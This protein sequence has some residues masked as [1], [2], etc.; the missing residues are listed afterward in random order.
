MPL[1]APPVVGNRKKRQAMARPARTGRKG[2]NLGDKR[3]A[4][5][6]DGL[7]AAVATGVPVVAVGASA[8]GL[9]PITRLLAAIPAKNGLAFVVIQHLDPTSKSLLPELLGR[10]TAMT[11]QAATDGIKVM[12]DQ[13]YVIPPGAHLTIGSGRLH[14]STRPTAAGA[15]LPI[16]VFLQSLATQCGE[17]GIGVILSGSG[18]DGAEGL[19]ALKQAGGLALVQDPEE[20]QQDSM[21]RQAMMIANPD[22]VLR[23][24][25]MPE[26]LARY[27]AHNYVKARPSAS[28]EEAREIA[29]PAALAAIIERLKSAT[30]QDFARYKTGTLQRRVER[31]MAL[32]GVHAWADYLA[33]LR[34]SPVETSALAKDLLINVTRFFRDAGAFSAMA[35]RIAD[36]LH[37]HTSDQPARIWVAG[38]S[39]GEEAYSLGILFREQIA[40]TRAGLGLQI[41]AT[42]IDEDALQIG[43]AGLYPGSIASDVSPKR[44]KQFFVQEDGHFKVTKELREAVIFSR[45][46]VL[47]DSPFS[48]LDLVSCRNLLIYLTP[49]AQAH[50]LALA[51][52]ALREGG[53]LLLGSA[54]SVAA[55]PGLFEPVDEKLRIYRRSG[56]G[57]PARARFSILEP[58]Q[59]S[60]AW[61]RSLRQSI[62]RS[63]S[64]PDLVQRTMLETYA[65][66]AVVTNRQLVPLYFFGGADRYL[67]IVSGEPG[68]DLL[69]IAREGLR[70]KLRD[71]IARAFRAKRRVSEHGVSFEREGK[72][73]TVTIEAQRI[74][75]EQEALV[76]VSFIDEPGSPEAA[77]APGGKGGDRSELILLR[78]QLAETRK[79][80]NRTIHELRETNEELKTKNEEAMSLNEEFLSTNE[81]L[82]SSKEELQSLNEELTTVNNQLRQTLQQQEQTS[83]DLANLLDSSA[84][85]TIMLDAQLRIK[86]FN[87]R[88]KALFSLIDADIGRPL[89]DLVPKF[90]D[91]QLPAD[92]QAARSTG[93]PSDREIRA[94]SG[95]W[96]VRSVLP[97]RTEAGAIEGAVVTFADVSQLK[98]AELDAAAARQYAETV[99][100]AVHDP[101]VVLNP[102]ATIVSANAAFC[103]AFDLAPD[104]IAGRALSDLER[105]FLSHERL[106][107]L[108]TGINAQ[109]PG[110]IDPV[111][112][113]GEQP[114]GGRRI[115]R[116]RARGFQAPSTE[117]PLVLL[118]LNDVTDERHI[119]RQQL[120]L[121]IDAMPGAFLAADKQGLIQF[122]SGQVEPLFGYRADELIGQRIDVLVPADMQERH[123]ALHAGYFEN[124]TRRPMGAGLKINGVTKDG[125]KIPLDIGLSP[126]AIADG[127]LVMVAVHDLQAVREGEARLRE[128][129]EAADR[130]N[131]TKSRFLA[132]ASHDLR[133][134]LQTIGFLIGVLERRVTEPET[135]GTLAKL[136]D[137]IVHMGELLDGLLDINQI[138]GGA[139]KP[140]IAEM[141]VAPLL[142]RAVDEFSPLAAAKGLQLHAVPSSAMILSDQRLLARM[143]GN[144]LSNAIKYTDHGKILIGCR[145][146]GGALQIE[147]WDTGIG[148]PPESSEAIFEEFHRVEPTDSGRFGMGLGLYIVQRFAHLLG[149]R[150][151]VRS[152][153]GKGSVFALV[154]SGAL[155]ATSGQGRVGKRDPRSSPP[156][157]LVMEDDATQRET[158]RTLL[159]LEGYCVIAARTGAEALAYF[160]SP[161]AIHPTLIVTDYNLPGAMTGL[162]VIRQAR[163]RTKATLPALIISGDKL[164]AS[165]A[166]TEAVGVKFIAKP[167]RASDLLAALDPL[168]DI[169]SPGWRASQKPATRVTKPLASAPDANIAVIDDEPSIRDSIR[170]MLEAEGYRVAAYP[171]GQAF[172]SDA[173][174]QRFRCLIVDMTL[175]GMDGL[176]LQSRL[177]SEGSGTAIVFVTGS[178]SLPLAVKAI[179]EGAVDFLQKPVSNAALRDSV[180]RVLADNQESADRG[181]ERGEIA[182]RLATLTQRERQVMERIVEGKLNKN[183]AIELGISQRTTEHHRQSVMRKIGA[184][185]L[186]MLIRMVGLNRQ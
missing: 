167:M 111:D 78:Q 123:A 158:L 67:K 99:I 80:L 138:E 57:R 19:K 94:E 171:S 14:L 66:A 21:P 65:P 42:D 24:E 176:E 79:E 72:T 163:A 112:L 105:P 164:E 157:V 50:V 2:G 153:P 5:S 135:R 87:P 37:G 108:V 110:I 152:V 184:S 117:H 29:D 89:A 55:A 51:H 159:E 9:E 139:I 33:L 165:R 28:T 121:M 16:N 68:Q 104:T 22:H 70:P 106:I 151:E 127:F 17:R 44:L 173:D 12:P 76:L 131:R 38:C 124:P 52:F 8:G 83:T 100:N 73:V 10:Q 15:G 140:Q 84:V 129:R 26:I 142:A 174:H 116:A 141:A 41:F 169:V 156:V 6:A 181:A 179:R 49:E 69:T 126:M 136:D 54:E 23:V 58:G 160:N 132:A 39:T 168:A 148:I 81:E 182:A 1:R 93:T 103:A 34:T 125:R 20:A 180:A 18:S 183:I 25:D 109:A 47:S 161:A 71:A 120:Q 75:D 11:V 88:M 98:Q 53:L 133:Q 92:A 175:P 96:Y 27:V 90:A 4:S 7:K 62:Q 107:A 145:R 177:K 144:L 185:S 13:V 155:F 43:R 115:W 113:E 74:A 170:E 130:A 150:V 35:E 178:A 101:L 166:A 162:D 85:A 95:A 36:L 82:E 64:L 102:N 3:G 56:R 46:D 63:P 60:G 143:V 114:G 30:G 172:L 40:A 31:R 137:A 154:I 186:A 32:H 97:Y 77:R 45:H 146:R 48:R 59:A 134:P 86:V 118:A 122:A 147:V 61:N 91:P 128:A 149:H 119:V